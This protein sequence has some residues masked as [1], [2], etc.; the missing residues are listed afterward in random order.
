[1]PSQLYPSVGRL[2]PSWVLAA[3][4]KWKPA[5]SRRATWITS[6]HRSTAGSSDSD[7]NIDLLQYNSIW[8]WSCVKVVSVKVKYRIGNMRV[9]SNRYI[10]LPCQGL[11][12]NEWRMSK[13]TLWNNLTK[14]FNIK[15]VYKSF[16]KPELWFKWALLRLGRLAESRTN[17]P[18]GLAEPRPPAL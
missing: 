13:L 3:I 11:S 9:R 8:N 4:S 1:M 14:K 16:K 17:R 18:S 5:F 15:L 2:D 6:N 12:M 7:S 10:S